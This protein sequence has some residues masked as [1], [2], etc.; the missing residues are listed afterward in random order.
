[1]NG[2]ARPDGPR[3]GVTLIE[4]LIVVSIM[5]LLAAVAIPLLRP[6]L[7]RR[8]VREASRAVSSFFETAQI[9]ARETGRP[10]GVWMVRF[11]NQVQSS[12]TLYQAEVPPPYSGAIDNATLHLAFNSM[13]GA[14]AVFDV[15]VPNPLAVD[16]ALLAAGDRLQLD[17]QGPWYEVSTLSPLQVT[18]DTTGGATVAWLGAGLSSPDLPFQFLRRPMRTAAKPLQ[19]PGDTVIDLY[20]S[21][22]STVSLAPLTGTDQ[23]DVIVMFSPKGQLDSILT[24]D[25]A[26]GTY[27]TVSLQPTAPLCL[28]IGSRSRLSQTTPAQAGYPMPSLAE[29]GLLNW[30]DLNNL[31]VTIF[32]RNGLV[33]VAENAAGSSYVDARKYALEGQS[34]GGR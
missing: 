14:L 3:R 6:M 13:A 19:L 22:T 5:L 24:F 34:V 30:Q 17:Y 27:T 28:L 21:G 23:R 4:M 2:T 8:P 15:V 29:D 18:L 9:H 16:V 31:W 26:S 11:E 7:A 1:M 33:T 32:P 20:A 25:R 12:F 10:C